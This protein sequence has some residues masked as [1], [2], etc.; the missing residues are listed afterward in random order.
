MKKKNSKSKGIL[1]KKARAFLKEDKLYI[2]PSYT[3]EYP[4]IAVEGKGAYVTDIE[5]KRFL[6]FSSGIGVTITGH[7]HKDIVKA[8]NLQS[9]KLIHMSGTDFYY[10]SQLNLAK[11]LTK[12]V[13][14]KY[15]KRVFFGNSGTEAIECA[16][17]LSRYYTKRKLIIGFFGAFHGRTMGALSITASK[18]VQK[19]NFFPLVPGITHIPYAHC[20]RCPAGLKYPSCCLACVKWIEDELF[21]HTVPPEEVAAIFVEPILGE[22]GYVVPPP[23]FLPE[24]KKLC[25][26][27]GILLVADEVQSGFGRT[28]KFLAIE[29][30]NTI[31]DIVTLA[32]GIASG[33][34]LSATVASKKIMSWPPGSHASTFGGNPVACEASLATIKLLK[35]GLME[36]A[37]KIGAYMKNKLFELKERHR[38]IGDVRGI[39][40]MIGVELVKDREKK[41][42]AINERKK[43]LNLCFEKGL[44]ILGCGINS[45]R[46]I[47]PLIISR[48][49]ADEALSIFDDVLTIVEKEKN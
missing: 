38:L 27:Y 30:F 40:L 37:A 45:I 29:H 47:P 16:I 44:V 4:L 13:P 6:D 32:K 5:G 24:L 35:E 39:G 43:V 22:G 28:G 41:T 20:Y 11:E 33:L 34:P 19:K 15:Q 12:L 49:E 48:N 7:C 46:F 23:E 21:Q 8:I 1:G 3:R 31:P 36:N 9:K 17:K 10:P 2:S 42:R 14:G 25:K 18:S 26:K